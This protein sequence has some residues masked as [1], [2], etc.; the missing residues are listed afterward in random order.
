[1]NVTEN[2]TQEIVNAYARDINY[3]L[4]RNNYTATEPVKTQ[5]L[6]LLLGR[7]RRLLCNSAFVEAVLKNDLQR[8]IGY[9]DAETMANLKLIYQAYYN[10]DPPV[11]TWTRVKKTTI[12]F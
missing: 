4:A 2:T 11:E 3:W 10:I 9:A 6:Y 12:D 7:D 8:T 5:I 1:M